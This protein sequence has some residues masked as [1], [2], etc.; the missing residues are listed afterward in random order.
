MNPLSE[1]V[2]DMIFDT[3]VLISRFAAHYQL[4]WQEAFRY[5]W[6]Y[7]G[8]AFA[9]EHY[10]FEHTQSYENELDTLTRV[11]QRNGGGIKYESFSR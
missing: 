7:G 3:V 11:C 8:M 1:K 5:L 10:E 4:T 9:A 2:Q 6:Q